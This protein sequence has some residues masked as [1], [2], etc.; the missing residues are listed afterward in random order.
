MP[1]NISYTTMC[2]VPVKAEENSRSPKTGVL[3]VKSCHVDAG[4]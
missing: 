2:L 3:V 4:Y 1:D